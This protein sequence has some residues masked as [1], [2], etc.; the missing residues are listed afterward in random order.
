MKQFTL[1]II[2]GLLL[3]GAVT[4]VAIWGK[5]HARA[6]PPDVTYPVTAGP[7]PPM[8]VPAP[9]AAITPVVPQ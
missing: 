2:L 8:R 1:Y 9:E 7:Q 4:A 3:A 5:P 6:V